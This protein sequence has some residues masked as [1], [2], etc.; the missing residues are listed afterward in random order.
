MNWYYS[1]NGRQAGPVDDAG[2]D[3]LVRQGAVRPDTLVWKEGM[4]GW[5]P[6]SVVRPSAAPEPPPPAPPPPVYTPPAPQYQQPQPQ[7]Q[8]F[9][10]QYQQPAQPSW[11]QP[12]PQQQ[13]QQG[14][15][16]CANCGQMFAATDVVFIGSSYVCGGCKPI[17]LQRMREGGAGMGGV[18]AR[19]YAGFWIRFAAVL[20]DGVILGVISY[21]ITMPI[22]FAIMRMSDNPMA[23]VGVS[24]I[25][26]L[27]QIGIAA[28]Y[29]GYFL[30]TKGATPGKMLLGLQVI[31]SDGSPLTFVRGACRYLAQ[32]VS[33]LILLIGY[34][35]AA[36]DTERRALHDHLCD[37]RVVYK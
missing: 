31:R 1:D 2:L 34:I 25:L 11:Q 5:Q 15:V 20:I 22:T 33:A 32:I 8:S 6:L 9:Q 36:F 13:Q 4:S 21:A 23:L 27:I 29:T 24:L 12:Q 14:G 28:G 19:R 16:T 7:A 17:F 37:T 35:I 3:G 10:P 26:N 18:G 30:S